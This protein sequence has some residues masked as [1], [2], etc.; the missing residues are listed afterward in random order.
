M[1]IFS[2]GGNLGFIIGPLIAVFAVSIWGLRGTTIL[3]IPT[4]VMTA[5]FFGLQ[6]RLRHFSDC[7]QK[8][9][10]KQTKAGTQVD[11]WPAL[12]KLCISVSARSILINGLNAFIPLYWVAIFMQTQQQAGLMVTVIALAYTVAAVAGGPLADRFGFSRIIRITFALALPFIILIPMTG[13]VFLATA[14]V[15]SL[16]MAINLGHAPSVVLG[17]RYLP[18][19]PGTASG[20][21]FGLCVSIGGIAAPILGRLGDTHG[22][23]V[24]LYVL[25][26]I[27]LIGVLATLLLKDPSTSEKTTAEKTAEMLHNKS[28]DKL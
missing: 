15:V 14:L 18:S 3:M 20:I 16:A 7:K 10:R 13:S 4:L 22:L 8:E 17:Q 23:T 21:I 2:A 19:R 5:V 11:N 24:V 26:G 6:K 28:L 1:G 12:S 9:V 25:A 27:L